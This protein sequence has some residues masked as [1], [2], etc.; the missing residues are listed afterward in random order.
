MII[1]SGG[2]TGA[3]LGALVAAQKAQIPTAGYAPKGFLT[4]KG[5]Q[6]VLESYGLIEAPSAN[7]NDRTLLNVYFSDATLIFA[8]NA[9]S[10]G[11]AKT[12][13]FCDKFEKKYLVVDPSQQG[14]EEKILDFLGEQDIFV[15]NVAGN[16]E[17]KA[18]GI[19]REVV[20]VLT[21][22]FRRFEDKKSR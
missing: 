2:Q 4:E 1:I 9:Q 7:Y 5:P 6:P 22:V 10:P 19:C 18:P 11:T 20:G 14:V 3:D 13:E 21:E 12:I 15:L 8:R 17:S 16:R